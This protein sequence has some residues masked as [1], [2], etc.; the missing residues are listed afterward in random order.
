MPTKVWF[1]REV[2]NKIQ[3]NKQYIYSSALCVLL[4]RRMG[5]TAESVTGFAWYNAKSMRDKSIKFVYTVG[6][7]NEVIE[8]CFDCSTKFGCR[9]LAYKQIKSGIP[10][11]TDS[12]PA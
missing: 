1:I 2:H 5:I 12:E 8:T 6:C 4:E 11:A 7:N 10:P 3:T 9:G